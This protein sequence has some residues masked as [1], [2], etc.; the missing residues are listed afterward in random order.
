VERQMLPWHMNKIFIRDYGHVPSMESCARIT[1]G[2]TKQMRKVLNI[3][4]GFNI[5]R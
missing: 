1:I 3:I 2:T 5:E 4:R